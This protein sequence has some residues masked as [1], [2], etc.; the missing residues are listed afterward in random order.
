MP[1]HSRSDIV[2]VWV[3]MPTLAA[4]VKTRC[5]QQLAHWNTGE[6]IIFHDHE[7]LILLLLRMNT[8]KTETSQLL[9]GIHKMWKHH[10]SVLPVSGSLCKGMVSRCHTQHVACMSSIAELTENTQGTDTAR[11]PVDRTVRAVNRN[12]RSAVQ[13][14][15]RHSNRPPQ[16]PLTKRH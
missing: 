6:K 2:N 10:H 3:A 16:S 11:L 7:R 14:F 5:G 12:T 9:Y 13:I 4:T 8:R 1:V 15:V